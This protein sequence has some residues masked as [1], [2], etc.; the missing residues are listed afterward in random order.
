MPNFRS[1]MWQPV[2]R[3]KKNYRRTAKLIGCA[4]W[5]RQAPMKKARVFVTWDFL[6]AR[7]FDPDACISSLKSAFDGLQDAGIIFNDRDLYPQEP[8]LRLHQPA[9]A[10]HLTIEEIQ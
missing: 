2:Y 8:V 10:V 3:A 5:K 4:E 9:P 7:H 6:T 1:K